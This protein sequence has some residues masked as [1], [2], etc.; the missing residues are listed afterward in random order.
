M[1]EGDLQK[2][3]WARRASANATIHQTQISAPLWVARAQ[4]RRVR[5][6]RSRVVARERRMRERVDGIVFC[7]LWLVVRRWRMA[8]L[9]DGLG[10]GG[11]KMII[12]FAMV[13]GSRISC[14]KFLVIRHY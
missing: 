11:S 3:P 1:C 12:V 14:L 4:R 8:R 5:N 10:R 9:V 7:W 13:W 2:V 6:R